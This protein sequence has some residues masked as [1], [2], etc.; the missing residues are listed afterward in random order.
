MEM[1]CSALVGKAYYEIKLDDIAEW[2]V[3]GGRG[4]CCSHFLRCTRC[5]NKH[6][7]RIYIAGKLPR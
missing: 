3:L 4:A 1:E 5:G 7:N 6:H 2:W